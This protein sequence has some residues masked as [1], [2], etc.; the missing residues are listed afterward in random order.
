M[1]F[2]FENNIDNDK[3]DMNSTFLIGSIT[4]IFTIYTILILHQNNLLNMN[5]NIIK[6]VKTKKYKN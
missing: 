5:D 2:F 3:L 4:K 1:V 6:Y